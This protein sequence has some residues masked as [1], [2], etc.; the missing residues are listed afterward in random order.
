MES[1]LGFEDLRLWVRLGCT[2]AERADPQEVLVAFE[3]RLP[4]LPDACRTDALE[5]TVCYAELAQ[6]FTERAAAGEY[7]TVEHLA[8]DL[9]RLGAARVAKDARL[10]LEVHKL[11]PPVAG[12]GGGVRFRLRAAAAEVLGDAGGSAIV[13]RR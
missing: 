11:R 7:R 5:G 9:F 2:A 8:W 4:G 10:T 12:L 6:V 3:A 1:Q 13:G